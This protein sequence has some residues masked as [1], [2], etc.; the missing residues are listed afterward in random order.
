MSKHNPALAKGKFGIIKNA[1][2]NSQEQMLPSRHALTTLTGGAADSRINNQ[3]GKN[4]TNETIAGEPGASS[5]NDFAKRTPLNNVQAQG[6]GEPVS[7]LPS[8]GN[9]YGT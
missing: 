2:K 3:Y 7:M 9:P 6:L 5:I 1:G 4:P 8:P